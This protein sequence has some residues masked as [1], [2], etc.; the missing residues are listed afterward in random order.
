MANALSELNTL[1]VRES[2]FE[3][4]VRQL[5][6]SVPAGGW[7]PRALALV[8]NAFGWLSGP[9]DDRR[10]GGG[11][12]GGG[13]MVGGK[14]RG[15]WEVYSRGSEQVQ[16]GDGV[17]GQRKGGS[18]PKRPH[19]HAGGGHVSVR[20]VYGRVVEAVA[21]VAADSATVLQGADVSMI[22][23]GAVKA[24][25]AIELRS[26]QAHTAGRRDGGVGGS[27]LV[28]D[29]LDSLAPRILE[30]PLSAF[31]PQDTS[32]I[33]N[34]CAR[35]NYRDRSLLLHMSA[36]ARVAPADSFSGQAVAVTMSAI[37]KLS[38][39]HVPLLLHLCSVALQVP[40]AQFT[41]HHVGA[42]TTAMARL[43]VSHPPLTKTLA[44]ALVHGGVPASPMA[45]SNV[46][47][48]AANL[49]SACDDLRTWLVMQILRLAPSAFTAQGACNCVWGVAVLDL[50]GQ[51]GHME[52]SEPGE[53]AVALAKW[54]LDA[55]QYHLP[56]LS[57][58][59][60]ST[61]AGGKRGEGPEGRAKGASRQQLQC[62]RQAEQ[63][64][65]WLRLQ[66]GLVAGSSAGVQTDEARVRQLL[67]SVQILISEGSG[68]RSGLGQGQGAKET[69]SPKAA[70]SLQTCV[71]MLCFAWETVASV[72]QVSCTY[73][74][75]HVTH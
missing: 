59:A 10:S 64:L 18:D 7:N 43:G 74:R 50:L 19:H 69:V 58:E 3:A 27:G 13:G 2:D 6:V 75:T 44:A 23:N 70:S 4:R 49:D 52:N 40:N 33:L 14:V 12:V 22:L 42:I 29:L 72:L 16:C 37:S 34:A 57:H 46:L 25:P 9:G 71:G 45:V 39:D 32:L 35:S 56:L 55:I 62:L 28:Q 60:S 24:S 67:D 61:R 48:A 38:F 65:V 53:T 47:Y 63:F 20:E 54:A 1:G 73:T 51:P 8:S 31:T 5:V 26:A 21:L 30:L 41:P 17:G 36:A 66:G 68:A 11:G 15:K